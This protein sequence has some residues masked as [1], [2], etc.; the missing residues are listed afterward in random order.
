MIRFFQEI[1]TWKVSQNERKP[2]PLESALSPA[3]GFATQGPIQGSKGLLYHKI[4]IESR[5]Q[6][7]CKS[8]E[9]DIASGF[10]N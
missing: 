3:A 6:D 7:P 5:V 8:N 2:D 1:V 10:T 9:C 4:H